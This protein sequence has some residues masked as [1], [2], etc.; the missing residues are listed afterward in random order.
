MG[1]HQVEAMARTSSYR[2][3]VE[4][5]GLSAGAGWGLTASPGTLAEVADATLNASIGA[6]RS[7]TVA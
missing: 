2:K 6:P 1:H 7:P 5:L 3:V 4:K